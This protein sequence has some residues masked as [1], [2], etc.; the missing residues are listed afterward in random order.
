[1]N[2]ERGGPTRTLQAI[3][4]D[5]QFWIPAVVLILGVGLLVFIHGR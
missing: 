4:T 5:I 3:L 1:M 2:D